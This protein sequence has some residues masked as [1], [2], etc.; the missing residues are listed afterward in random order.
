MKKIKIGSVKSIPG[1]ISYGFFDVLTHP[2]GTNERLPIIIAQGLSE[3]PTIWI[4]GN[5]H[6]N[7]YSGIS[8]IHK[9]LEKCDPQK[10]Q[11][12]IVAIPTLNPAGS[13]VSSR[14]PYYGGK[15]P[16]RLFPDYNPLKKDSKKI[17]EL[18]EVLVDKTIASEKNEKV[19]VEETDKLIE[20]THQK[21]VHV[22]LEEESQ[23]DQ[24]DPYAIFDKDELY[25]SVQELI[26]KKIFN[27]ME[28]SA[29]CIIDLHN[30]YI[31]SL[32]FIFFDRILYNPKKGELAR[33]QAEELFGR[34]KELAEAFGFTIIHD[35]SVVN[36][37]KKNL[38]R[39]IAGAAI[40]GLGIPAFTV[41]LGMYLEVDYDIAH[42]AVIGINNVF[43]K[44]GIL[45]GEQEKVDSV[46]KLPTNLRYIPYPRAKKTAI[47]EVPHKPGEFISKGDIIAYLR[48]I[49]GRPL[50]NYEK[51]ISEIN[52]YL[53]MINQGIFRY[54]N[55]IICWL[56]VEDHQ[57]KIHEWKKF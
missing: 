53:F 18:R 43:K 6:G 40:N 12:T 49:F 57:P 47:I 56:A 38:H 27:L 33:K 5:I 29:D 25:P 23:I 42:A 26:L 35:T 15:D 36:Y 21:L 22:S 44:L 3:G 48:D 41:E 31:K 37:I 13:R 39:S 16:N 24:R 46:I 9:L 45:K 10:I 14:K 51:I 52:G 50:D 1:E 19:N 7:E 20:V 4:T 54:T 34:T 8:V 55:E 30:S 17:T 28:K 2:T 11:G 32:P